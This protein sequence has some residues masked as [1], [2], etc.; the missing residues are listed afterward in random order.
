MIRNDMPLKRSLL[1]GFF[2]LFAFSGFGQ[3]DLLKMLED[4]QGPQTEYT[5]ATFK[6][7]RIVNLQS[8]ELTAKGEMQFLILHRFGSFNDDYFYNFFGLNV[9]EVRLT[10]DYS[11]LDWLNLGLGYASATPRTYDGFVKYR[12][13]RQSK[14]KVNFPVSITG[15]SGLFY[16]AER[17]PDDGLPR[18]E[19]ERFN[20]VH[21]LVVARKFSPEFSMELV[22][23]LTHFN[24]VDRI[25]DNNDIIS[26]GMAARYKISPQHAISV[27]YVH[28]LNPNAFTNLAEGTQENYRGALSLGFD[29]ETGGHVFQLFFTNSRAVAEPFVF[30]QTPGSWMDGDIHFGFNISR[31]FNIH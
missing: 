17:F 7:T 8:N 9:A 16:T 19:S 4:E 31:M 29:I 2:L 24:L 20:Y 3:D 12:L 18:N 22:P 6:G 13:A 23:A 30:A 10:V 5:F 28:P 27:E 15:Y 11:P 26:I 21:Q 14:G 25:S 1:T